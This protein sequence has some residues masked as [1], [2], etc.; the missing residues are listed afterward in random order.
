MENQTKIQIQNSN[1]VNFQK[2]KKHSK[3]EL[4]YSQGLASES[5]SLIGILDTLQTKPLLNNHVA[6]LSDSRL[7]H[8]ANTIQRTHIINQ[9]QHNYG[10]SYVQQVMKLLTAKSTE[11]LSA[12]AFTIKIRQS[13]DIYKKEA[14]YVAGQEMNLKQSIQNDYSIP[15]N[16]WIANKI[17]NNSNGGSSLPKKIQSFMESRF[18]FNFSQVRI[19]TDSNAIQLN[20]ELNSKAFT[21]AN[22]IYFGKDTYNPETPSG[23]HLLAHEL[24]HV[25]QQKN[26]VNSNNYIQKEAM[27]IRSLNPGAISSTGHAFVTMENAQNQRDSW[28]FYADCAAGPLGTQGC[29]DW[30]LFQM[31]ISVAVP[32]HV[33]HE[34]SPSFDSS[35]RHSITSAQY[36]TANSRILALGR[37]PPDYDLWSYNCVDFVRTI[38]NTVG[39]S[40]PDFPGIDEPEELSAYIRRELDLRFL[41]SGTLRLNRVGSGGSVVDISNNLTGSANAPHFQINNLPSQH[42]FRFRW[43]ISDSQ[44]RSYLMWGDL[45]QV[46]QY[47]RQSNAY[48][49]SGTRA[50]LRSRD[51]RSATIKCRIMGGGATLLLTL[52]VTFTW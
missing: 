27:F 14:N 33:K 18:G 34:T 1:T 10:N 35:I 31:G 32:G 49:G 28:G 6:I 20:R 16:S 8:P 5:N 19:H 45:G 24:T 22:N 48:I 38:A 4:K 42:N 23:K 9:L 37:N 26:S 36:N 51:I 46:F 50:L 29:S 2:G 30:E 40:I 25:I 3:Q 12:Q 44:D 47:G 39:I 52:P 21:T 43:I 13:N 7:S 15:K 41:R 17:R 11:A